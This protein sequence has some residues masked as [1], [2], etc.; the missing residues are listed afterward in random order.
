[1]C[2][3]LRAWE[4]LSSSFGESLKA[5]ILPKDWARRSYCVSSGVTSCLNCLYS[6]DV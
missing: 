1:M 2:A 4:T 5:R 6:F 3:S